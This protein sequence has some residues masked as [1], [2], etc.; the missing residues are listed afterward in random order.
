MPLASDSEARPRRPPRGLRRWALHRAWQLG[1]YFVGLARGSL[2]ACQRT[3]RGGRRGDYARGGRAP[4][5][6][7]IVSEHTP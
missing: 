3:E 6:P 4:R 1:P 7:G 5:L 2:T